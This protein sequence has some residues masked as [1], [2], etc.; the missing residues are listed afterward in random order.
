VCGPLIQI[1]IGPTVRQTRQ[2]ENTRP[3]P[4]Q[5]GTVNCDLNLKSYLKEYDNGNGNIFLSPKK[6]PFHNF[7]LKSD[8]VVQFK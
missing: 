3:I 8:I 1:K 4:E 2:A 5:D 7:S 6:S